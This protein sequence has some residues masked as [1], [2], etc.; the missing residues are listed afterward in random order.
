M[1]ITSKQALKSGGKLIRFVIFIL[2]AAAFLIGSGD[3]ALAEVEG[4]GAS[5]SGHFD[6]SIG[7]SKWTKDNRVLSHS[8]AYPTALKITLE[9]QPEGVS[10]TVQ[11]QVNE[12]G[13]GWLEWAEAGAETGSA[14]SGHPLEALKVRL[15]GELA[16]RYDI[17]TKVKQSGQWTEWVKNG[18]TVGSE[19]VGTHIA[20]LRI[21]IKA[22]DSG[23]PE[24]IPEPAGRQIDPAKPMVA[25]TYDDGPSASVTNRIL[26]SLEAVEGRATFFVIGSNVHGGNAAAMKRAF[27]MG[28]EI[29]NHTYNHENLTKRSVDAIKSTVGRTDQKVAEVTGVAP[30]LLRPPYGAK[31]ATVLRAI[32]KPAILW[33][34]DTL[35]WKT[36]NSGSTINAVLNHVKDGDIILMHDIYSPTA[37]ASATIIPEL[38]NRGYQ[39]VTVTELANHRGGLQAGK[40]YGAFRR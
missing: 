8:N 28:C 37:D 18:E 3:K 19:G 33:S 40:V 5:Y 10:G 1:K 20:A 27:D 26:D 16:E 12:S 38:V 31:N 11:Y 7:W 9:N 4:F 2:T 24:D 36:K 25:L 32:G 39:L 35:D 6:N 21:S 15:N 30:T 13:A 14:G 34:I 17:Y 29:G 23:Q 22:K